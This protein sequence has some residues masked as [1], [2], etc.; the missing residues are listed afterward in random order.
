MVSDGLG[1]PGGCLD[2]GSTIGLRN[3][4]CLAMF[5]VITLVGW[6]IPFEMVYNAFL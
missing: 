6:P 2:V 1:M 4:M 5:L 3:A